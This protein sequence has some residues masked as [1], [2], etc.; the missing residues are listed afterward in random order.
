M[1]PV[2]LLPASLR[3]IDRRSFGVF[4]GFADHQTAP[5]GPLEDETHVTVARHTRL[6]GQGIKPFDFFRGQ[7]DGD[8]PGWV[9]FRHDGKLANGHFK[10]MPMPSCS[11][12]L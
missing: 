3:L 8:R 11:I 6:L 12:S 9:D 4:H 10:I 1:G 2:P 7:A 5:H